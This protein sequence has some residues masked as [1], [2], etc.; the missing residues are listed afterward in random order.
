MITV[1]LFTSPS[2]LD[3]ERKIRGYLKKMAGRVPHALVVI[4]IESDPAL[5]KAYQ[6]RVPLLNIG[7][8]HLSWPFSQ[9]ELAV[10][11]QA[12][13]DRQANLTESGDPIHATRR[14]RGSVFGRADRFTLWFSSHYMLVFNLLVGLYVG[15]A[16]FAPVLMKLGARGPA[17]VLYTL[18]SP[19][20]HQ[21][22]YRSWFLF[23]EQGF[24]P[25]E[26][27][28]IDGVL[29]YSQ[30]TGYDEYDVLQAKRFVGNEVIGYKVALC[31]RDIAIYA[32]I[33]L[34]GIIFS[35]S[36]RKIKSLPWY[37]WLFIGIGPMGF[38]GASQ[39]PSLIT[40]LPNWLPVR[41][42]T[43][44]LRTITGA[45]FGITTAWYG[46]PLIDESVMDSRRLLLQKLA[47]IEQI[48]STDHDLG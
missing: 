40:Y 30:V 12:A 2:H 34:F 9:Q 31:E 39:L 48:S 27:A 20:C 45:L 29:T 14:K 22:A 44:L 24:Y 43:P 17:R 21:L 5:M 3:E 16:F 26:L 7:P 32:G 19:L 37:V 33:L 25:R 8:Y 47:V 41:E 35:I 10:S 23:G 11:L 1:S 46:Y 36:G 18:Y 13:N 15:L 4:D 28:G 38:D 42:S 6:A